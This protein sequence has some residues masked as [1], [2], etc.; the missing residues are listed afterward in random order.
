ML[1]SR[2]L[3]SMGG[4][5]V[6]VCVCFEG[7]GRFFCWPTCVKSPTTLCFSWILK[8][9]LLLILCV[10]VCVCVLEARLDCSTGLHE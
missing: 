8:C 4:V 2:L 9:S 1:A 5:C 10:C 7:E 6:F 3:L